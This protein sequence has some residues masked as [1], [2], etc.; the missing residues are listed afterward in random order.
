MVNE[1]MGGGVE[2]ALACRCVA[3]D[4]PRPVSLRNHAG[5]A[6]LVYRLPKPRPCHA[7]HDPDRRRRCVRRAKR[8]GL[9]GRSRC[10]LGLCPWTLEL[11]GKE[12]AVDLLMLAAIAGIVAR[13]HAAV[14]A[15]AEEHYARMQQV[16]SRGARPTAIRSRRRDHPLQ[17]RRWSISDHEEPDPIF[18]LQGG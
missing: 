1:F 7:R 17:S 13:R 16:S 15:R 14:A 3:L 5:L 8:V 10:L 9:I 11:H 4:D 18:F 6:C 12:L 2:R